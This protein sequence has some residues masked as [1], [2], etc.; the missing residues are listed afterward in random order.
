L[1]RALIQPDPYR[2]FRRDLKLE[3]SHRGKV[4]PA[5][6][7]RLSWWPGMSHAYLPAAPTRIFP[8][9]ILPP[10]ATIS[11]SCADA[12]FRREGLSNIAVITV[13]ANPLV[14]QIHDRMPA[15]LKPESYDRWLGIEPEARDLLISYPAGPMRMWPI[16]KRVNTPKNDDA[17]LLDTLT[18]EAA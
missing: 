5:S 4:K 14:S 10:P 18:D 13:P 3:P 7:A 8:T 9:L 11:G 12:S 1:A 17:S 16:S 6:N 2:R 15:I